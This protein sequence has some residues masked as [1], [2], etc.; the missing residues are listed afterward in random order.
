M[1]LVPVGDDPALAKAIL[2]LLDAPPDP[3]QLRTRAA[4]FSVDMSAHRYLE[5]LLESGV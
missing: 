4:D 2:S 1:A 3:E 5:L